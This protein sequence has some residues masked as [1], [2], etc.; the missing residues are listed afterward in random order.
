[1]IINPMAKSLALYLLI[2]SKKSLLVLKILL[3][4]NGFSTFR[5]LNKIPNLVINH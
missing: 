1:M 5:K 3:T 2:F 4:S